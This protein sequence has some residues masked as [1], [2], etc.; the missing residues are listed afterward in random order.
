MNILLKGYLD[1]NF[2][3]DIM[4][5]IAAHQL[6]QHTFYICEKKKELLLPFRDDVNIKDADDYPNVPYDAYLR[7]TGSGFLI[8]S[9]IGAVETA[10]RLLLSRR[11]R[12]NRPCMS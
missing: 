3:D 4:L 9:K 8:R 7:V 5:R 6:R 11:G 1:R 2:G 12:K 10:F